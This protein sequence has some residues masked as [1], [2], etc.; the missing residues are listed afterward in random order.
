M[1][2]SWESY[3]PNCAARRDLPADTLPIEAASRRTDD[4][5]TGGDVAGDDRS[6][7]DHGTRTDRDAT[8]HHGTGTD[9]RLSLDM[10]VSA[11][12]STWE[13]RRKVVESAV[14]ADR[15][16]DMHIDVGPK[17]TPRRHPC[18][19]GHDAPGPD[20][21]AAP[22]TGL[23]ADQRYWR[24]L[25]YS[26]AFKDRTPHRTQPDGDD[27]THISRSQPGRRSDDHRMNRLQPQLIDAPVVEI[28][29]QTDWFAR[30]L[31]ISNNVDNFSTKSTGSN[32]D[33]IFWLSMHLD[34]D[35][36]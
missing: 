26:D 29:E 15:C 6:S 34:D 23:G 1:P 9:R 8:Q 11:D 14:V 19:G 4:H 16:I 33:Q 27:K 20:A 12:H 2:D 17:D 22:N 10:N 28:T 13:D 5:V 7:A 21:A 24:R 35:S 36:P 3:Y 18:S 31:K 32:D 25:Q 30:C